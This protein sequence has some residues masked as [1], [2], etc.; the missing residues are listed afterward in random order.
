[1]RTT[2]TACVCVLLCGCAASFDDMTSRTW[3]QEFLQHPIQA[4]FVAPDP[5]V[6]LRDS[7]DGDARAKAIKRLS[8]PK[9]SGGSDKQQDDIINILTAAATTEPDPYCRLAAIEK[10]GSF[11]DPRASQA[12]VAAWQGLEREQG[13]HAGPPSNPSELLKRKQYRPDRLAC[14]PETLTL[15]QTRTLDALARV[16]KPEAVTVLAEVA[17]QRSTVTDGEAERSRKH[18]LQLAAVRGL[19]ESKDPRAGVALVAVLRTSQTGKDVDVRDQTVA[20]LRS[21]TGKDFGSD[22]QAWAS[23]LRVPTDASGLASPTPPSAIPDNNPIRTVGH[24]D[25]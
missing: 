17:A 11:H 24:A 8:E 12:L 15:I 21:V 19:G 20:S 7:Q 13:E 25:R 9:G 2:L 22:A 4:V 3:R 23:H 5:L 14:P 16:G 18:T 1:M 6:V 10:L